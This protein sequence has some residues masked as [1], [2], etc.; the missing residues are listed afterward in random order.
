MKRIK[1]LLAVS[2]LAATL[3]GCGAEKTAE[4]EESV[5][6]SFQEE[7]TDS[8]EEITDSQEEVSNA[9]EVLEESVEETK[10]PLRVE[11]GK[12]DVGNTCVLGTYQLDKEPGAESMEWLIVKKDGGKLLLLS[13][14]LLPEGKEFNDVMNN[15]TT[16]YW[17]TCSLR[18]WLNDDFYN[19]AFSSEE[20]NVILYSAVGDYDLRIGAEDNYTYDYVFCLSKKEAYELK[21]MAKATNYNSAVAL[22]WW[23]RTIG[24]GE[25]GDSYSGL[26]TSFVNMQGHVNGEGNYNYRLFG[27]RP[28]IWI[29]SE[30]CELVFWE[31][32]SD[33]AGSAE[34]G[35]NQDGSLSE[36]IPAG[37]EVGEVGEIIVFGNYEQD[38]DTATDKEPLEWIV[39]DK[40]E[41]KALLLCNSIIDG[42]PYHSEMVD[43]TW[44][45]CEL[46]KWCNQDFLNV[47]FTKEEQDAIILAELESDNSPRKDIS[48]GNSTKDKVFCLSLTEVK[49]YVPQEKLGCEITKYAE[50]QG[51]KPESIYALWGLRT[52][53]NFGN[54]VCCVD[55]T[56]KIRD[57]GVAALNKQGVRPAIWVKTME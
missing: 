48:G 25:K 42:Q 11:A 35:G 41:G 36:T 34:N 49:A 20:K 5:R 40:Q 1:C 17:D 37:I 27:V 13:K 24:T 31:P 10:F 16:A 2:I 21:D 6:E 18:Q 23:L 22:N 19:S 45:D 47:A 15:Y 4:T 53:G 51:I 14:Y 39:L 3:I 12:C 33:K 7:I 50:A 57:I 8:Q 56:G 30:M 26:F 44:E 9:E 54:Y 38:N 32:S 55:T 46:R 29:D 43:I 28:A 52:P